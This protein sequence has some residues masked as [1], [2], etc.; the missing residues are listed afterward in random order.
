MKIREIDRYNYLKNSPLKRFV[1]LGT[2]IFVGATTA[3]GA[4]L[5]FY[6]IESVKA[7]VNF[8]L[9]FF[10]FEKLSDNPTLRSGADKIGES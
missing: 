6:D 10:N 7:K 9:K 2:F 8:G 4:Y 1:N 3:Y 5:F